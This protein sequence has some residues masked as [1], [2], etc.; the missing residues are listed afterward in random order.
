M[1]IY[2]VTIQCD[3]LP[4]RTDIGSTIGSILYNL[5]SEMLMSNDRSFIKCGP[6]YYHD[7]TVV[8]VAKLSDVSEARCPRCRSKR[9]IGL[10]NGGRLVLQCEECALEVKTAPESG[11][12]RCLPLKRTATACVT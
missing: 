9:I 2:T 4:Q 7:G 8:G 10:W 12:K 3:E 6:L 5:G 11:G 1:P